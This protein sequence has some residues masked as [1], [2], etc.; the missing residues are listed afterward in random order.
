MPLENTDQGV[1]RV[2][3]GHFSVRVF[4]VDESAVNCVT[5]GRYVV[6]VLSFARG[7]IDGLQ[8]GQRLVDGPN[9]FVSV[10]IVLSRG[11]AALEN[12]PA[13]PE[14]RVHPV[15]LY[16]QRELQSFVRELYDRPHSFSGPDERL[17][18][19]SGQTISHLV[20]QSYGQSLAKLR[21]IVRQ[22]VIGLELGVQD[23]NSLG[24]GI[25]VQKS[26]ALEVRFRFGRVQLDKNN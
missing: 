23:L 12:R 22:S 18:G 7:L 21:G 4:R 26:L 19:G 24:E 1:L 13:A 16:A 11:E 5:A 25:F 8:F 9:V 20:E 17:C 14:L 15:G 10:V 2:D 6:D 3:A